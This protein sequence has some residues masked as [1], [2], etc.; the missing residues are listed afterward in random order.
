MKR[1]RCGGGDLVKAN[2]PATDAALQQF[3][4]LIFQNHIPQDVHRFFTDTY[5]FLL[6]KDPAN[7]QKLRPIGIPSA[8]RRIIA[9][10]VAKYFRSQFAHHLLPFNVAVG[11]EGGMD[12]AIKSTAMQIE[13]YIQ[14]PQRQPTPNCQ[15]ASPSSSTCAICSIS[16]PERSLCLS[17]QTAFQ[18]SY[19]SP[20]SSMATTALSTSDGTMGA[21]APSKW[22]KV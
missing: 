4:N 22:R 17:S 10:H 14:T 15:R 5:L 2:N 20:H 1:C 11:V 6:H 13:R 19:P 18:K 7:K 8:M 3:F 16:S 21:G 9:S 12:F